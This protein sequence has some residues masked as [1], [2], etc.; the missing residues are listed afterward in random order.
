MLSRMRSLIRTLRGRSA[1]EDNMNDEMRFHLEARTADLVRRGLSPADAARRA[2]LEFGS[3]EKQKDL[4]RASEVLSSIGRE[5]QAQGY[6]GVQSWGSPK[7]LVEK[8][9]RRREIVGEFELAVI[10]RYGSLPQEKVRASMERFGR[11]V[12]PELRRW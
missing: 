12:V 1:F 2:R 8:L 9:R 7:T 3:I 5:D 11:E 10:A 4:A 6:L